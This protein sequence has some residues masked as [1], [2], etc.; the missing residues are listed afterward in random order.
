MTSTNMNALRNDNASIDLCAPT[1]SQRQWLAWSFI[2][3]L[4][5]RRAFAIASTFLTSQR[6]T[7]VSIDT[8]IAVARFPGQSPIGLSG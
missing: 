1:T 5:L 6:S 7:A 8:R 3:A 2:P 4:A